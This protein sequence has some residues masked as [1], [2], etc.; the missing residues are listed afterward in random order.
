M[1][2]RVTGLGGLFFRV[3]DA[4]AMRAWYETHFGITPNGPWPQEK[5][6]SVMGHFAE[7]SDYWPAD[8]AFMFNFRVE[9]LDTIIARLEAA[10]ITVETNPDWDTPEIGR[11]ARIHDP[12]GNPIELWEPAQGAR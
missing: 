7:D 10:G 9:G 8:R 12:E 3:K 6:I 2:A 1:S 4:K 11:F 5:G